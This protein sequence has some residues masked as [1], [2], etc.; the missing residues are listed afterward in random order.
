M[1][2]INNPFNGKLN[3]DVADYRIDNNDYIDA[4]NIT[5]DAQGVGQDRVVSNILSNTNVAYTLPSG[6]N[7][8][9]G[10]YPDKIRN[11]AYYFVWNSNGYDNI[12]YLDLNTNKITKVLQSKTDSNGVDILNF[13]PSYKVLSVNIFYRD[14]EGDILYFNDGLNPPKSI[15]LLNTYGTSWKLEYLLIAK[16]PPVMPPKVTFENDTIVTVNNLRNSLYQFC[17]RFVYQNNEKSVWSSR[18]IVPLPQQN[19]L[20]L[21]NPDLSLNAR[22]SISFSTGDKDVKAIELAFREDNN[23][24]ISDFYLIKQLNKFDNQILDNDIYNYKFYNDSIYGQIDVIETAQLQD[25]VP[26]KANAAELANGNTLLYSGITEGYN[27]T[28]MNLLSYTPNPALNIPVPITFFQDYCGLLF[29]ATCNGIDS[30][31][32]GKILKIY[33]YGTGTNT[34]GEVTTL[35]NP[36]GQYV[37]NAVDSSYTNIGYTYQNLTSPKTVSSILTDISAGLVGNG[38]N[39]SQVSLVGNILTMSNTNDFTLYSSG[40]KYI[41]YATNA[42]NNTVYANAWDSGYQYGIQY[43]DGQGRTIGTQTN[44]LATF[45]TNKNNGTRFTQTFLQIK[46]RPPLEARYFQV[47]RSNNTTYDKRLFWICNNAFRSPLSLNDVTSTYNLESFAYIDISNI[48]EYNKQFSSST[49]VV[50]YAFTP[51]DR[52]TFL[53]R[54]DALGNPTSINVVDFEILG[55]E[56]LVETTVGQRQ[57]NFIKIKYPQDAV[58]ADPTNFN[59]SNDVGFRHYEIFLYNYSINSDA[60]QKFF[61]EFNKCFGI[62]NPGTQNAYHIGLE[63]SQSASDPIGV[64]AIISGTNGDLFWRQRNVLYQT[65][66]DYNAGNQNVTIPISSF[67]FHSLIMNPDNL[68][69]SYA[70]GNDNYLI[71]GQTD[72]VIYPLDTAS[73]PTFSDNGFFWNKTSGTIL[74]SIDF[75]VRATYDKTTSSVIPNFYIVYVDSTTKTFKTLSTVRTEGTDSDTLVC[76]T[77]ITIPAHTKAWV[78][79]DGQSVYYSIFKMKVNILQ[80]QTISIIESSFNDAYNLTMN[81]NGRQSVI[82]VNARNVYFPTLIRFSQSYQVDTNIN[83][84]NSF[85]FENFDEYDRSFGDVMRL[86]VRDRYLKVFQKFKVG[87]VPILTQIIKDSANNPLQAN[88]DKLINKI[89]Y[90]EGNYGIG[91]AATSLAWNNFSDYFVDD[92]RGVVCRLSQNGIEPLSIIYHTNAFFVAKLNAYRQQLNNG[93]AADGQIYNGNPCIYGVFDSYTNKYIIAME[94]INRYSDCTY[95]GGIAIVYYPTSTTT[96]T[97]SPI[98]TTST[99]TSTTTL[100]PTTTTTTSTT[101]TTTLAPITTTTTNPFVSIGTGIQIAGSSN[102]TNIGSTPEIFLNS[103][104]YAKFVANGGCLSDGGTNTVS[105]IRNSDGSA[106]SGTFYFVYYGGSCSTTTFK[107][108]I[109]N[110]TINPTQC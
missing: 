45:T 38:H 37:I 65:L 54:Y 18:S 2:I 42:E 60:S 46:N 53:K 106:I 9:I 83:G 61:Y 97:S 4:L 63:Q 104:D 25:W 68:N 24:V 110:L 91:D 80:T 34:N 102:C 64:P 57:G 87:N 99:T 12:L 7:K 101:T 47:V 74:L 98:T 19:T 6:T 15:N 109:G 51:G 23:N 62:G 49:S 20:S 35:N 14:D 29:F 78:A 10:F 5:K 27:K 75:S 52:I 36:V 85:Y 71:T 93:A 55:T 90:Y 92:Y 59:F 84:T 86:H 103:I 82:D 3:L 77:K 76:S 73:Y 69:Y 88:T 30:G 26:Q 94:E 67:L 58:D 72:N 81:S 105:V 108:T 100:A 11:R 96:T 44:K 39:W 22:I 41:S 1:P 48:A 13:N 95:N 79:V 66:W 28:N 17:Y 8:V 56:G 70:Y 107:S 33:L 89:Q 21:T 40:V 50:S 31:S 16:A 32:T 43:F